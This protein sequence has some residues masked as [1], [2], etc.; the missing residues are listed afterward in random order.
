M[1]QRRRGIEKRRGELK[2]PLA[3]MLRFF[4]P[5]LYYLK[6]EFI[7]HSFFVGKVIILHLKK[8]ISLDY[9][10]MYNI[11]CKRLAAFIE[12]HKKSQTKGTLNAEI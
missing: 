7:S 6:K 8:N 10:I 1:C 11:I 9:P 5:R 3:Q 12:S 4:K 2:P